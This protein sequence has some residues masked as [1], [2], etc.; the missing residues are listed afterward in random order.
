MLKL[1]VLF[2]LSS[3]TFSVQAMKPSSN[4]IKYAGDHEYLLN[5]AQTPGNLFFTID[6]IKA[7]MIMR[8]NPENI[9]TQDPLLNGRLIA[10][11]AKQHPHFDAIST[12]RVLGTEGARLWLINALKDKLVSP[13]DCPLGF[14]SIGFVTCSFDNFKQDKKTEVLQAL[15]EAGM[16]VH[17]PSLMGVLPLMDFAYINDIKSL[18]LLVDNGAQ[19]NKQNKLYGETAL[20]IA[21]GSGHREATQFLLEH[22]ADKTLTNLNGQTALDFAQEKGYQNIVELLQ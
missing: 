5:M 19:V 2:L 11:L 14:S 7:F 22:G 15:I 16:D 10:A 20:M 3:L 21:A 13:E 6:K 9:Y 18:T 4:S 12:A 1:Q 17:R 8:E